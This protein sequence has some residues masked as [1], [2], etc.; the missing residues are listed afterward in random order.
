MTC[1]KFQIM[2][3]DLL[4]G[5]LAE[6]DKAILDAHL[7]ECENCRK[8]LDEF[9]STWQ[10]AESALKTETAPPALK[11]EH[12]EKIHDAIN[13]PVKKKFLRF[14]KI[15]A[16]PMKFSVM[17][18]AASFVFVIVL[19]VVLLPMLSET[20]GKARRI[21][22]TN[23]LKQTGL[24]IKMQSKD[25]SDRFPEESKGGSK[26]FEMLKEGG[27]LEDAKIY[28]APSTVDDIAAPPSKP[29]Q[30]QFR[31]QVAQN[32]LQDDEGG[33]AGDDRTG[34][35]G[36]DAE[37]AQGYNFAA[38]KNDSAKSAPAERQ[39]QDIKKAERAERTKYK[40]AMNTPAPSAAPATPPPAAKAP[41]G[42]PAPAA[43]AQPMKDGYDA[44]RA[45]DK[46]ESRA[47][48][49]QDAAK[50]NV[51]SDEKAQ[52]LALGKE[53][54]ASEK[55]RDLGEA[56]EME[57]SSG[58]ASEV[59]IFGMR[60]GSGGKREESKAQ[61]QAARKLDSV[62]KRLEEVADAQEAA[63]TDSSVNEVV[64]QI[65]EAT[66]GAPA[67][68]A[69]AR[70]EKKAAKGDKAGWPGGMPGK[71]GAAAPSAAGSKPEYAAAAPAKPDSSKLGAIQTGEKKKEA[72]ARGRVAED[73]FA[74]EG[75]A[76]ALVI[77]KNEKEQAKC[78]PPQPKVSKSY[79]LD[80]K[81]WD[82]TDEATAREFL[83][84]RGAKFAS[85]AEIIIDKG[86]N[87]ITVMDVESVLGEADGIFEEL[88]RT[89][90]QMR[91]NKNG[92]PFLDP[93]QKPFSTF[94][95]DVDTASY[96]MA[97]K[98]L[99]QGIKPE[100]ESVRPEEFINYFDYHYKNPKSAIF[101]VY[102]TAATSPFRPEHSLLQI[103]VQAMRIG[104]E[105]GRGTN[106]TILLDA[107]GSMARSGRLDLIKRTLPRLFEQLGDNGRITLI[108]CRET[109]EVLAYN[110]PAAQKESLLPV[111]LT[112]RPL[113]IAD[114]E[115]GL[116]NAYQHAVNTFVSGASNRV[117][118]I[119]DGISN[120]GSHSAEHV[121][122]E[123]ENYRKIGVTNTV[124]AVGGDGD[125]KFL[126]GIANKGDGNY[127]YI[128]TDEDAE[129]L[130]VDEFT[131]RF[132]EI[133]RN[134][135]IQVEFRPDFVAAYRQIGYQNRQLSK[136][137]FR[138]DKVDA[139]EVGAGQS[140]TA[141]Y[142]MKLNN[143][144]IMRR[145]GAQDL[146]APE[147]IA[148]VRIRY[149]RVDTM[150]IEE[151][152]FFLDAAD[153]RPDAEAAG[154]EFML[155]ASVAEFAEF[156]RFPDVPGIAN[157]GL[158]RDRMNGLLSGNYRR[159]ARVAELYQLI[160]MVK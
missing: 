75:E 12:Y 3:T 68:L 141:L 40:I 120:L 150:E 11:P 64:A 77:A 70:A 56:K 27:Y 108:A 158:I 55:T 33:I 73:K 44:N 42:P 30:E 128:E 20:R 109:P 46:S 82:L 39:P 155:A 117:V 72:A 25:Y 87:T 125:D 112:L 123:V 83:K 160:G 54:A 63:D 148:V 122:S 58:T 62:Q 119:T 98:Q 34:N 111:L 156:L 102:L 81:L 23:S 61:P 146:I 37:L 145:S 149:Q 78:P 59:K 159:D 121:L 143:A 136:A 91:E 135:K 24:A 4:A 151:K 50:S 15:P 90:E 154:D 26:G 126:E 38:W 76:D 104:T 129:K 99:R 94:S 45:A 106:L 10:M 124:V 118:L 13:N 57:T 114:I 139:G 6:K 93:R 115:A 47:N 28:T 137:D 9:R 97:R 86:A 80:L 96:T 67:D 19:V 48:F 116:V 74:E 105:E 41:A 132:H 110:V 21:N 153:I 18:T 84:R 107:S 16:I 131:A 66:D 29:A 32:Q 101:A 85:S 130:F 103:G 31:R 152:E 69:K 14:P 127:V 157:P 88:R 95:I 79:T 100:P 5:E 51:A 147:V 8:E 43:A 134:V 36:T 65:A 49:K 113:G 22:A 140:V 142:E 2:I 60:S 138:N 92:L 89:E 53:K 7:A 52:T 71:G 1:E 17:E 144:R 133:A 35:I